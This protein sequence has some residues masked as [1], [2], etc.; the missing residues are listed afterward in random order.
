[1]AEKKHQLPDFLKGIVSSEAYDRWLSRKAAAHVKRDRKR[2]LLNVSGSA[3]R[4]AI[5]KAVVRSAGDDAYTGEKLDWHLISTYD[6]EQSKDGKHQYKAGFALLPTVDHVKAS[7]A[8]ATF[9]ICAWRTNDAKNDLSMESFLEL[10]A[11]A[12]RHAGYE[13]KHPYAS[14]P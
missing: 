2:G 3:Y 4:S 5:H 14:L 8:S 7:S 12:L 10:C 13:V 6:N 9:H 1:M 11:R